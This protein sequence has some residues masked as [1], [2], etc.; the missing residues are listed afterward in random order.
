MNQ[1]YVWLFIL[2][3]L[4]FGMTSCNKYLDVKPK[5]YQL[6]TSVPDYD[7]WLN[8]INVE[9]AVPTPLNYFADNVDDPTIV[10]NAVVSYTELA[11]TWAPQLTLDPTGSAVILPGHYTTIYYFN[12][13]IQGIDAATGGTDQQ[14][15]SLKA[16]AQLGRALEYLYLVNEYGKEY[17]S[18]TA[19]TDLAIPF[20]ASNDL[21]TP[22]PPRSTV[23]QIYDDIIADITA[24][25][26]NLPADKDRKSVV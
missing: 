19:T 15:A 4:L 17:D 16:E 11:Y 14:K 26:P 24:A 2:T 21:A 13:V 3:G 23:Q 1:K 7:Q 10:P 22:T 20:V 8:S 5:G 25:I 6:L 18:A 12:T 9:E